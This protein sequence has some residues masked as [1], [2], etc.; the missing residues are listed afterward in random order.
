MK[1]AQAAFSS[2][3]LLGAAHAAGRMA[4]APFVR[5]GRI[6]SLPGPLAGWT[7][8]R[9]APALAPQS[10]RQWWAERERS[11]GGAA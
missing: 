6:P 10:F 2:A 4:Q 3:G 5:D 7:L 9:D 8:S 1:A 11:A